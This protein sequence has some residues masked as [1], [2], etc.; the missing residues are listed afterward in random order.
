MLVGKSKEIIASII[1]CWPLYNTCYLLNIKKEQYCVHQGDICT[2]CQEA[3]VLALRMS[4]CLGIGII[5]YKFKFMFVV[6]YYVH[7]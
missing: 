2:K 1:L 6:H 3:I 4:I 5:Y 7:N